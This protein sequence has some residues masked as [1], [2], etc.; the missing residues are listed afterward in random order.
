[1]PLPDWLDE[2]YFKQITAEYLTDE[3]INGKARRVWK[4]KASERDN[5]LLDCR[6]YN[7]ALAEY[8]GLSS[9][10]PAEWAALQKERGGPEGG[11]LPLFAG[12]STPSPQPAPRDPFPGLA[13]L[14][15]S[16]RPKDVW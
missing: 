9:I 3:K 4:L 6:V 1:L 10:T 13:E 15:A 7:L 14:N 5:H 8:L 12:A 2:N 16:V 11:A